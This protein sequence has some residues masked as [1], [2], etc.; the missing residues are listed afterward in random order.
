MRNPLRHPLAAAAAD[1][2]IGMR[3][4]GCGV[5]GPLLCDSCR[6]ALAPRVRRCLPDPCPPALLEP[7]PVSPWCA[8]PYTDVTRRVLI[9]FKEQ[10]RDGLAGPLAQLLC[11]AVDAAI[12]ESPGARG[13]TLVPMASRR[14]TVRARGYDPVLVLTR[15]AAGWLRR[16]GRDVVVTRALRHRRRVA[17][18][19]GLS[20]E[21]RFRNLDGALRAAVTRWPARRGVVV[22]DD[23]LT[24]GA[25][26]S[27]AVRAL[28]EAGAPVDRA[29]VV[30]AT[31]R[32]GGSPR[33]VASARRW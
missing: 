21:E 32:H 27:A 30:A 16:R 3:C 20:A 5:P 28:R 26:L 29:A 24:T 19:A 33:R 12:G 13:W 15:L 11:A 1:L 17:D 14:A 23:V 9:E 7:V 4:A 6:V 2:V 31:P 25:T 22:V 8:A 18:Q 10:R